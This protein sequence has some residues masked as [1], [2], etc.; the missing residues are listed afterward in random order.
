MARASKKYP[1]NFKEKLSEVLR[2][3]E[4]MIALEESYK[5]KIKG[6]IYKR[7]FDYN[8]NKLKSLITEI[9]NWE[10]AE[11]TTWDIQV[12]S[13]DGGT[14]WLDITVDSSIIQEDIIARLSLSGL[15][16]IYIKPKK[17]KFTLVFLVFL[18]T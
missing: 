5:G 3:S 1:F 10:K 17:L 13:K 9:D 4:D 18:V 2:L 16:V 6:S 15:E 14:S 7:S 11:L 12:K 8:V